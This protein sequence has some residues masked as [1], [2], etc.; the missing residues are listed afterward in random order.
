MKLFDSTR[1]P[2]LT[3][4]LDAYALRHKVIAENIANVET[5]GY[6]AKTVSFEKELSDAMNGRSLAGT[7]T[8]P[9]HLPLGAE[10]PGDSA[11]HVENIPQASGQDGALSGVNQVDIDAE[12]TELA[13]NQIRFRFAARLL[14]ESFRG[15]QKSIRGQV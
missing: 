9:R 2:T 8:D 7:R 13:T 3:R 14:G 6:Q 15:I 1:I 5:P 10:T 11:A 12:M 4:A